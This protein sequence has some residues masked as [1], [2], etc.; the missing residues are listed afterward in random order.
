MDVSKAACFVIKARMMR[1][2]TC[3]VGDDPWEDGVL[4]QVVVGA[5]GQRVEV[6]QVLEV[7]DLACS[8]TFHSITHDAHGV[9]IVAQ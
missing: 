1:G 5:A 8:F 3:P 4:R 7:A 9:R 6:H 2:R